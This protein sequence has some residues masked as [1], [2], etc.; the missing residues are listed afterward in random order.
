MT[1][2]RSSSVLVPGQDGDGE[3]GEG[4][5]DSPEKAEPGGAGGIASLAK[6]SPKKP[7]MAAG[8]GPRPIVRKDL[9]KDKERSSRFISPPPASIATSGGNQASPSSRLMGFPGL[10][11]PGGS[12][13]GETRER[14]EGAGAS[15]LRRPAPML[16]QQQQQQREKQAASIRRNSKP[17]GEL[18]GVFGLG[19]SQQLI[20]GGGG[21]GAIRGPPPLRGKGNRKETSPSG[22]PRVPGPYLTPS[23]S[24]PAIPGALGTSSG[25]GEDAESPANRREGRLVKGPGAMKGA[26]LR[27]TDDASSGGMSFRYKPKFEDADGAAS[28]VYPSPHAPR[29]LSGVRQGQAAETERASEV[30]EGSP[31]REEETGGEQFTRE[32]AA[33]P[34]DLF[35]EKLR[36]LSESKVDWGGLFEAANREASRRSS[37]AA[38]GIAGAGGGAHSASQPNLSVPHEVPAGQFLGPGGRTPPFPMGADGQGEGEGAEVHG[39]EEGSI[40]GVR[41]LLPLSETALSDESGMEEGEGRR[42]RDRSDKVKDRERS[43]RIAKKLMSGEGL[44]SGK[45]NKLHFTGSTPSF[46]SRKPVV[47]HSEGQQ[48]RLGSPPELGDAPLTHDG[49]PHRE[50]MQGPTPPSSLAQR[51]PPS[52]DR[53]QAIHLDF[54]ESRMSRYSATADNQDEGGARA[55]TSAG[56][57]QTPHQQAR[58]ISPARARRTVDGFAGHFA[59]SPTRDQ[60]G[61]A[62]HQGAFH[63]RPLAA[64]WNQLGVLAF[65]HRNPR[66]PP[67]ERGFL[68]TPG[69]GSMHSSP[70]QSQRG[71][72]KTS[73][74]PSPSSRH[75]RDRQRPRQYESTEGDAELYGGPSSSAAPIDSREFETSLSLSVSQCIAKERSI[76]REQPSASSAAGEGEGETQQG[77]NQIPVQ[78]LRDVQVQS[79]LSFHT[80]RTVTNAQDTSISR[81]DEP[82]GGEASRGLHGAEDD[83]EDDLQPEKLNDLVSFLHARAKKG[84]GGLLP[85]GGQ[86]ADSSH[87][88]EDRRISAH[89]ERLSLHTP[90]AVQQKYRAFPGTLSSSP[91]QPVV[92]VVRT[93]ASALSPAR[94]R[95]SS[96][97]PYRGRGACPGSPSNPRSHSPPTQPV[98]RQGAE[99]DSDRGIISTHPNP[100]RA[101]SPIA[102]GSVGG[103]FA[104]V[105]RGW[106][107]R[108]KVQRERAAHLEA[109]VRFHVGAGGVQQTGPHSVVQPGGGGN[110]SPSSRPPLSSMH[111]PIGSNDDEP[112]GFACLDYQKEKER[113]QE[114]KGGKQGGGARW[115]FRVDDRLAASV[116]GGSIDSLTGPLHVSSSITYKSSGP[117]HAGSRGTRGEGGRGEGGT[118]R[119]GRDTASS[120]PASRQAPS[121]SRQAAE[122]SNEME[123]GTVQ[124]AL[125]HLQPGLSTRAGAERSNST[126]VLFEDL[127][128][129]LKGPGPNPDGSFGAP[130]SATGGARLIKSTQSVRS[131]GKLHAG[132]PSQQSPRS[133]PQDFLDEGRGPAP[134]SISR[135]AKQDHKNK[136]SH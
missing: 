37:L 129:R 135:V 81:T 79:G 67:E 60:T 53:M 15:P 61:G 66:I 131:T 82:P 124:G 11:L 73:R 46:A 111:P 113:E 4:D 52:R 3:E 80:A 30:I 70:L 25:P 26:K 56:T 128:H 39:G 112:T 63:A 97:V 98:T 78:E 50:R 107:G 122:A 62:P 5:E 136:R 7:K 32:A 58:K 2:A 91:V 43:R 65:A 17:I 125:G 1:G 34:L 104:R 134:L 86:L 76:Q 6:A 72:P 68:Q 36:R 18:P 93:P 22:S 83:D 8:F 126:P 21:F 33:R 132:P 51:A 84:R 94:S 88:Q 24:L 9:D 10:G 92:N 19:Q 31:M 109:E 115:R 101:G 27:S 75:N 57:H 105:D 29:P 95:S 87:H 14:S 41:H 117:S 89:Q 20:G 127:K 42:E 116:R 64:N 13:G 74:S 100:A 47:V 48:S 16:I 103:G 55:H 59:F 120:H 90:P 40:L 23:P 49:F 133:P 106:R 35:R 99:A 12:E 102:H 130:P 118:S 45:K 114:E 119:D 96:P 54:P 69:G 123:P 110:A 85:D 28:S 121:S 44:H 77:E 38:I 71:S 108:E